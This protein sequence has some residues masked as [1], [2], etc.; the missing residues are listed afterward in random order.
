MTRHPHDTPT[1]RVGPARV[2]SLTDAVVAI[3]MTLLVLPV[4]DA[5]GDAATEGLGRWLVDRFDLLVSFVVSFVVIY[6]FWAVH[7]GALRA[8]EERDTEIPA[9]RLLNLGW[10]LVIAFLPFPTAV[11]GHELDT[12][13]A[14]LYIGTMFL[15]AALTSGIVTL[16]SRYTAM[17]GR[18]RWAW[19]V[20]G[21]FGLCAVLGALNADLGMYALLL[22][23]ILRVVETRLTRRSGGSGSPA[24]GRRPDRPEGA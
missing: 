20:T 11:V 17:P 8:L 14:P 12:T 6:A 24:A 16:T 19:A 13:T 18:P 23:V 5:A 4:V 1:G 22:L 21:V 7:A 10:L 2:V 9:L 15:L 3:A